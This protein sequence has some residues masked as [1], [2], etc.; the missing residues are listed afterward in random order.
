ML[1]FQPLYANAYSGVH[2]VVAVPSRLSYPVT[3]DKPLNGRRISVKDLFHL[4]GMV[5][6]IGSRSYAECYGPQNT[7]AKYLQHLIDK[8]AIIVGK[9]KM[10]GYA[11]SEIPPEKCID[12]FAPWN[13]RGDGYQGPS[14]SSSGAGASVAGYKWLDFALATDSTF[15]E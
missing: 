1:R 10:G 11:G 2:S 13:P 3:P 14:G 4:E 9:T 5:T 15:H 7:T 8:G 12:Y 6:T